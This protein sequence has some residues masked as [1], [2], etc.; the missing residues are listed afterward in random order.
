MSYQL[1]KNE[2]RSYRV[3]IFVL[4]N[5]IYDGHAGKLYQEKR[6][7]PWHLRIRKMGRF[8]EWQDRDFRTMRD[9]KAWL[10]RRFGKPEK[11]T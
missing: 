8:L 9:A 10:D 4:S 11:R 3:E 2:A 7:Q 1:K 6:G 5:P